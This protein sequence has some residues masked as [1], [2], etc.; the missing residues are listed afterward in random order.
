MIKPAIKRPQLHD[1]IEV[2]LFY[3]FWINKVTLPISKEKPNPS[4]FCESN[5]FKYGST[6][7]Q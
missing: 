7:I 1:V 5:H 6:F 4:T 3:L 2:S